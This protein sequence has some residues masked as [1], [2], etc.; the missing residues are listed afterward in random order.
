MTMLPRGWS[1]GGD[2]LFQMVDSRGLITLWTT[3]AGTRQE[4]VA[5]KNDAFNYGHATVSPDGR[6][7]A[8][9]T[10]V[11]GGYEVYVDSFPAAGRRWP[12]PGSAGGREPRWRHDGKELYYLSA[13]AVL[14]ATTFEPGDR[15]TFGDPKPL[16]RLRLPSTIVP[17]PLAAHYDVARDGRF[18]AA[19]AVSDAP[20]TAPITVSI[21]ATAALRQGP[22]K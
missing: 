8:Y 3:A 9:A 14:V 16:F 1:G 6:W 15:P 12:V 4:P 19:V 10:D 17:R 18:L 21:N 13:D 2:L 22:G 5:F 11:S 7:I 20:A